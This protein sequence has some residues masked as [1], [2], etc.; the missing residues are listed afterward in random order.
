[1][2]PE[3]ALYGYTHLL[4]V[5]LWVIALGALLSAWLQRSIAAMAATYFFILAIV[6]GLPMMAPTALPMALMAAAGG[7]EEKMV[8]T[9]M[10]VTVGAVLLVELAAAVWLLALLLRGV[11]R[12]PARM[13]RAGWALVVVGPVVAAVWVALWLGPPGVVVAR[14][15]LTGALVV[16]VN[17]TPLGDLLLMT[18]VLL[19]EKLAHAVAAVRLAQAGT[20][21][22]TD[23]MCSA[24]G[25]SAASGSRTGLGVG[26]GDSQGR[27]SANDPAARLYAPR[28]TPTSGTSTR[29]P[30]LLRPGGEMAAMGGRGAPD[31]VSPLRVPYYEVVGDYSR[32][33]EEALSRE[34]IP[35]ADRAVVR[36]YFE[37]L[38]GSSADP[39]PGKEPSR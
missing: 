31:R 34:E 19:M 14:P 3:Q 33:A 17:V 13:G 7:G 20:A 28:S 12:R 9:V 35:P 11:S 23:A 26:P 32:A 22:R 21:A 4:A 16:G 38:Q 18:D 37:A 30:S 5:A 2:A 10:L 27:P 1:M 36:N 29:V 15:D 39:E 8:V 25:V 6:I 24:S